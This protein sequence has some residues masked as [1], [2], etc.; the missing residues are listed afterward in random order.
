MTITKAEMNKI[1]LDIIGG[2]NLL[3]R[4]LL[5]EGWTFTFSKRKSALGDCS[6]GKKVI[7]LSE[8][9]LNARTKDE[10]INTITHEMAHAISF[11]DN[12]ERG[13]GAGWK[14]IH[15]SLGGDGQRCSD[16][17]NPEAVKSKYVAFFENSNGELEILANVDKRTRKFHP[18]HIHHIY[19]KGRK[20]ETQGKIRLV[21]S[22]TFEILRSEAT[23]QP[24]REPI[25][26]VEAKKVEKKAA[27]AKKATVRGEAG[28]LEIAAQ[29]AAILN[30]TNISFDRRGK[31]Q[32]WYINATVNGAEFNQRL[33][34]FKKKHSF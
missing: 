13:H 26:K 30:F 22:E 10:Q 34:T 15:R 19:V 32:D 7:R 14:R 8:V 20:A 9:Y 31:Y 4:D 3:K 1:A 23:Q 16:V 18:Q 28:R 33:D 2:N 29:A 17:S 24:V 6:Y 12:R 27:P 11:T 25:Q 21:A 5:A